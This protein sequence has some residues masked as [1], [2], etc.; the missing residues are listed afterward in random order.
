MT[1]AYRWAHLSD[2]H[3]TE[4]AQLHGAD[5]DKAALRLGLKPRSLQVYISHFRTQQRLASAATERTL[6]F[7][8]QSS[9]VYDDFLVVEAEDGLFLSDI[10]IPNGDVVWLETALLTAIRHKVRTLFLLGDS[11][12]SNQPGISTWLSTWTESG[13]ATFPEAVTMFKDVLRAMLV[14]FENI[15]IISGNHDQRISKV[16]GGHV[17]LGTLLDGFDSRVH[18]SPYRKM[19]VTNRRGYLACYHQANFSANGV[20]LGRKMYN[21]ENFRGAKPYALI[22][23]HI[24]HW[25]CGKSEDN[26]GAVYSLGACEDDRLSRYANETPSTFAKRSQSL[27]IMKRGFIRNLERIETDWQVELGALARYASICL[28]PQPV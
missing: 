16:T 19:Y 28:E 27:I 22:T 5:L 23:T 2:D 11:L 24:H 6:A 18:F 13:E 21:A 9:R 4:I 26:L 20:A 15:Y 10:H 12:D 25:S 1:T 7:P 8:V 17:S 3:R 14:W